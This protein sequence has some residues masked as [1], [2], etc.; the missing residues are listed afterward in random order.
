MSGRLDGKVALVTGGGSGIGRASALTFLREG[1]RVA[2]GAVNEASLAAT[3]A[4]ARARGAA[5]RLA[6]LRVDV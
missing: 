4:L 2:I 6:P 1:A 3:V 5:E